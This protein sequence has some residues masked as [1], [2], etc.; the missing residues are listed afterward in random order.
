MEKLLKC[1]MNLQ[2]E[3]IIQLC[4]SNVR[5]KDQDQETKTNKYLPNK[6]VILL[7]K[8]FVGPC[9]VQG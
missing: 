2:T 3:V 7:F 1:C 6:F 9:L 4:E 5:S 8:L